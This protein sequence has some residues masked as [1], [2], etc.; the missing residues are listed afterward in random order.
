MQL[1]STLLNPSLKNEKNPPRQKLLIF[2]E[3][4]LSDS[5]IKKIFL[6]RKLF[7]CFQI[8]PALFSP[9]LKNKKNSPRENCLYSR[10]MELSSSHIEKFFTFSQ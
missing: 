9:S 5:K 2:Q 10:K 1:P 7:L 8:N 4:E 6:K 3:M